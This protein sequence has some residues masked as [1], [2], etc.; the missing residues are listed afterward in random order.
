MST[1]RNDA[2]VID[3]SAAQAFIAA[4]A[5]RD[6]PVTFQTFSE[7]EGTTCRPMVKH[8][9]LSKHGDTLRKANEAGAGVFVTINETNLRGR[10]ASDVLKVRAVFADFDGAPLPE[11]FPL[12]PNAIIES[13]PSKWHAYWF[14]S[15]PLASFRGVQHSIAERFG[16]DRAVNDLPRVMR[17]PGFRHQKCEPFQTRI[18]AL[19][20]HPRYSDD[21]ILTAFPPSAHTPEKAPSRFLPGARNPELVAADRKLSH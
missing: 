10:K 12:R 11:T 7:R 4:L 16:S 14:C 6:S 20:A 18:E 3:L 19:E 9:S 8:G 13:S 2:G 21:E 1:A 5:G 15:I 17:L